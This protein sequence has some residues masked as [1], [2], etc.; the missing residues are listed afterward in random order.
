VADLEIAYDPAQVYIF[1][2]AAGSPVQP[3]P[4]LTGDVIAPRNRVRGGLLEYTVSLIAPAEPIDGTGTIAT[5]Q[6]YPL[7]PGETQLS[8]QRASLMQ[9]S[10]QNTAEGR[11][12]DEP[13]PLPFTPVLLQVTAQGETV[14]VPDEVTATPPPTSTPIAESSETTPAATIPV[15]PTLVNITR[16]PATATAAAPDTP[17]ASPAATTNPAL[18]VALVIVVVTGLGLLVMLWIYLRRYRR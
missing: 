16:A 5:F 6:I 11:A 15:E 3:G 4:L 7:R 9:V 10:F 2:T 12:P 8:F 1:G 17:P 14:P 13:Q 18:I